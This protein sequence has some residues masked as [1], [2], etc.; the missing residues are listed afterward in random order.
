MECREC[1][2]W[3]YYIGTHYEKCIKLNIFSK[4]D[5]MKVENCKHFESYDREISRAY[6]YK[7]EK[8]ENLF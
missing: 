4:K 7:V 8:E 3:R 2:Y 1:Q 6:Y 5:N